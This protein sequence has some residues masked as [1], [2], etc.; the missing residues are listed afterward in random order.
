MVIKNVAKNTIH[1]TNSLTKTL[2]LYQKQL[3]RNIRWEGIAY[4]K[5]KM[6]YIW[7]IAQNVGNKE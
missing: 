2:L 3:G 7:L 5:Q 1:L 6:L 4:T